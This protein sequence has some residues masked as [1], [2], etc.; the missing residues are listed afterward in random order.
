MHQRRSENP[1]GCLLKLSV[2]M[3]STI[4]DLIDEIRLCK[5]QITTV[6]R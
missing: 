3:I 2:D 6:A 1:G 5:V 4:Q